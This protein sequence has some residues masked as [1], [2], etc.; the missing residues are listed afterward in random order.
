[1]SRAL[2]T[3]LFNV[4][5]RPN[6]R[7]YNFVEF[8]QE[9]AGNVIRGAQG[10]WLTTPPLVSQTPAAGLASDLYGGLRIVAS[11]AAIA[12]F[13]TISN[14]AHI[15]GEQVT[16]TGM[17]GLVWTIDPTL[18]HVVLKSIRAKIKRNLYPAAFAK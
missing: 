5:K 18:D 15:Q 8:A 13:T 2:T 14:V 12:N 3:E 7:V 4:L 9:D 11:E 17:S 16:Q 1:M 10:A 6:P